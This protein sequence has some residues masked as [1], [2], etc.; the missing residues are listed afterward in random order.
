VHEWTGQRVRVDATSLTS[1]APSL[2]AH[3]PKGAGQ[4]GPKGEALANPVEVEDRGEGGKSRR[5]SK[6]RAKKGRGASMERNTRS[7]HRP[8]T[9]GMEDGRNGGEEETVPGS[10]RRQGG[11]EKTEERETVIG[12]VKWK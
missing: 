9:K 5:E 7:S 3:W 2:M 8:G 10:R 12:H 1:S 11:G 4:G 6:R